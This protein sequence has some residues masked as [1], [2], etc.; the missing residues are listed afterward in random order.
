MTF[1]VPDY[2]KDAY[3]LPLVF[4]HQILYRPSFPGTFGID[5]SAMLTLK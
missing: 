4:L 1:T 3:I 2:L 5:Y